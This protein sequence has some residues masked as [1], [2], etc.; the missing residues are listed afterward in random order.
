MSEVR[1]I[2]HPL[3]TMG[4]THPGLGTVARCI[5]IS[6]ANDHGRRS[7]LP[8]VLLA[9]LHPFHRPDLVGATADREP[10][11]PALPLALTART[12]APR[13]ALSLNRAGWRHCVAG[14]LLAGLARVL[15]PLNSS[16]WAHANHS[17]HCSRSLS[18]SGPVPISTHTAPRWSSMPR[19]HA[20][21]ALS[22]MA[23]A[24]QQPT[25][26]I[27]RDHRFPLRE[28]RSLGKVESDR[29]RVLRSH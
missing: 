25:I 7:V 2:R 9:G 11:S 4:D 23:S 19:A 8:A 15:L 17:G 24:A 3:V 26:Q 21:V 28:R 16:E 13:L 18:G 6:G 29:Y 5:C 27:L 10:G 12:P 22:G 20:P 14:A 1:I